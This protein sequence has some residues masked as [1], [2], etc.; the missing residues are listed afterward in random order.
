MRIVMAGLGSRGDVQPMAALGLRLAEA[1]HETTLAV[2]Q[3]GLGL[4]D[5]P[6]LRLYGLALDM[7][8]EMASSFGRDL[9]RGP[10]A[11]LVAL[12]AVRTIA[13]RTGPLIWN[14]LWPLVQ[15]ADLL[16]HE[17]TSASPILSMAEAAGIPALGVWLQPNSPTA[18]FPSPLAPGPFKQRSG[19]RNRLNHW[20]TAQI[21][22]QMIR[23]GVNTMRQKTLGLPPWPLTGPFETLRRQKRPTLMAYSER[24]VPR[25][26]DWD[27]HVAVTGWFFLDQGRAYVPSTALA[28]FLAAGPPPLYV[29]FGSMTLL[30]PQATAEAIRTAARAVGARLIMAAGWGGLTSASD[31]GEGVFLLDAVPHD[32][33]FPHMAAI[34]HHGGAGTTAAAVRA[35]VPSIVVP[36]MADQCFWGHMLMQQGVCP[37]TLPSQTLRAEELAQAMARTLGDGAMR[38]RAAA[39]GRAVRAEDG[40][41]AAVTRIEAWMAAGAL[42]PPRFG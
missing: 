19:W 32:W 4:I 6:R 24:L 31:A 17:M 21:L 13:N 23:P 42:T 18:A 22:W 10:E 2:P 39:L 14:G 8:Q 40:T 37:A 9:V 41:A 30:N 38:E 16:I 11:P 36:F 3:S 33:L 25:P 28:T 20:L 34:I 12:R 29:G 26:A 7:R 15:Q 1:G 27:Q 5:D 35:G